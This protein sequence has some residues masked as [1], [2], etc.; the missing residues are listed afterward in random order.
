LAPT[1]LSHQIWNGRKKNKV[2]KKSCPLF[3][4]LPANTSKSVKVLIK[5]KNEHDF[6]LS[7]SLSLSRVS[8][9]P[10]SYFLI[11]SEKW[12]T[13]HAL[14][15]NRQNALLPPLLPQPHMLWLV[16]QKPPFSCTF[17]QTFMNLTFHTHQ[18][19]TYHSNICE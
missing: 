19:V 11:I 7:L 16:T 8:S 14:E 6:S 15:S 5:P 9:L 13:K 1:F 4:S 17:L 3:L 12:E 18:S 10:F 2:H